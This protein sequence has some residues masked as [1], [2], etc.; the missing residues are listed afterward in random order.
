MYTILTMLL[1]KFTSSSCISVISNKSEQVDAI[2]FYTGCCCSCLCCCASCHRICCTNGHSC[3]AMPGRTWQATSICGGGGDRGSVC[4]PIT[5]VNAAAPSLL[6]PPP[7][8]LLNRG[9][10][11]V[12]AP[13]NGVDVAVN[14]INV[15]K[16]QQQQ[17]GNKFPPA[18]QAQAQVPA[19]VLPQLSHQYAITVED[20]AAFPI[21]RPCDVISRTVMDETDGAGRGDGPSRG[22][23][24]VIARAC[25]VRHAQCGIPAIL[26]CVA[27]VVVGGG[28]DLARLMKRGRIGWIPCRCQS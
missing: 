7:P 5:V 13:P 6:F 27:N 2:Y 16:L 20:V 21:R 22:H 9:T 24:A 4:G 19:V 14:V 15:G 1:C 10:I 25:D 8:P 18:A 12:N 26:V 3:S 28:R 23:A 17:R 11:I